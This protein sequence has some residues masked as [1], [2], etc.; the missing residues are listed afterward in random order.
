MGKESLIKFENYLRN[1]HTASSA[2]VAGVSGGADSVCLLYLLSLFSQKYAYDIAVV[3][4]NHCI[5]GKE[6]DE[7]EA[8]VSALCEKLVKERKKD[9][10]G[11]N[12]YFEPFR[13]D[14]P[15]YA[16]ECGLSL[17][18]AG[19]KRRYELF[20]EVC[21]KYNS[22]LVFV[23][24]NA[25]DRAETVLFNLTRGSSLDGLSGIRDGAEHKEGYVICRP[26]LCFKRSEIEEVLRDNGI[27]WRNDSTNESVDYSRNRIRHSVIPELSKLNTAV[28]DHINLTAEDIGEAADYIKTETAKYYE[29]HVK[30]NV[31]LLSGFDEVP[32]FIRKR[33]CHSFICEAAGR[34]KDIERRHIL[35]LM[36][37]CE[38]ESGKHIDLPYG[39]A[40]EKEY[41]KIIIKKAVRPG[42][43]PE[44][45]EMPEIRIKLDELEQGILPKG[46]PE[47][48][49]KDYIFYA[50]IYDKSLFTAS[51][52]KGE[53]VY[54][55]YDRLRAEF[56]ELVFRKT[57]DGDW[58]CPFTDGRR[59]DLNRFFIDSKTARQ[60]REDAVVLAGGSHVLWI[61]GM[62]N[63][64]SFRIDENTR[65]VFEAGRKENIWKL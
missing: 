6:A 5:R 52:E 64:E 57:E 31:L 10:E 53:K 18:E 56:D 37:L 36:G 7:D 47:E 43:G 32:L 46:L 28:I 58:F 27:S 45:K 13:E 30:D 4:L 55:D 59:K 51:F 60:E 49:T 3:H 11:G 39:L 61:A 22:K 21:R 29:K 24:H 35:A 42:C 12:I 38:G 44:G 65:R 34:K 17:E 25:N 15:G 16:K 23:A 14:I 9:A 62:R 33:L 19:R 50:K 8:F 26:L 54:F 48:L 2:V 40:A 63:D 41:D 20:G 1:R